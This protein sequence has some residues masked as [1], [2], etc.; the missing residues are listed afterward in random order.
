[1]SKLCHIYVVNLD[2]SSISLYHYYYYLY[3]AEK[4]RYYIYV[5]MYMRFHMVPLLCFGLLG[6]Q[7]L[8]YLKSL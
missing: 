2:Y 8:I 1:M 3:S 5:Y 4:A 7:V 6:T